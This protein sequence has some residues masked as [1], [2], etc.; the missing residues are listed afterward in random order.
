MQEVLIL[1]G[2]PGSGRDEWIAENY[3]AAP[4]VSLD[5]YWKQPG[6]YFPM[7][8][9]Q[10]AYRKCVDEFHDLLKSAPERVIVNNSNM[11]LSHRKKYIKLAHDFGY[12][13]FVIVFPFDES[14]VRAQLLG[15]RPTMH[16][17]ALDRA[18]TCDLVPGI[19]S[20]LPAQLA[21]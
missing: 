17:D 12:Q 13:V 19:Y 1:V 6:E 21:K 18:V 9:L 10:A 7:D 16:A 11:R 8:E 4:C 5:K 20:I 2:P 14:Q 3:P 15:E